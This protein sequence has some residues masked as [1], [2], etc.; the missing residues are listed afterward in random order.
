M[1]QG[2]FLRPALA[3]VFT[4]AMAG[5]ALAADMDKSSPQLM[6]KPAAGASSACV[7]A[8]GKPVTDA[9]VCASGACT[10]ASGKTVTDASSCAVTAPRDAAS[11]MATGKRQH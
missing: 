1:K 6:T 10:D 3:A 2:T 5:S 4:L 8:S 9:S 11:G 7:D